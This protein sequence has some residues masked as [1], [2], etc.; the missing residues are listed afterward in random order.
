MPTY[1][2]SIISVLHVRNF[3]KGDGE[4]TILEMAG[5]GLELLRIHTT[6]PILA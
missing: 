3:R 5:L 4:L 1:A 6:D 2:L